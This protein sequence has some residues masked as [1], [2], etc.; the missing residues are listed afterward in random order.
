MYS[1]NYNKLISYRGLKYNFFQELSKGN[2]EQVERRNKRRANPVGSIT[3]VVESSNSPSSS[4][5]NLPS[6]PLTS[7]LITIDKDTPH[8]TPHVSSSMPF[9]GE[10]L[11]GS[12]EE[13]VRLSSMQLR[14]ALSLPLNMRFLFSKANMIGLRYEEAPR[15]SLERLR[16]SWLR[17]ELYL[18]I[19][20]EGITYEVV[21]DRQSNEVA[22]AEL[23]MNMLL[24]AQVASD[25]FD[26]LDGVD[27]SELG[28]DV[29]FPSGNVWNSFMST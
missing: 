15:R 22:Q 9:I 14:L 18:K 21:T 10:A 26:A 8:H 3:V 23:K 12:N 27:M 13:A 24:H 29:L 25:P 4:M 6:V 20:M 7:S 2:S 19:K 11:V 16:Q 17:Y 28:F 5:A 1:L